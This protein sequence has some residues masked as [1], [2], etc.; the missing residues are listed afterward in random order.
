MYSIKKFAK[1]ERDVKGTVS[2][3]FRSPCGP[4]WMGL[5]LTKNIN[6]AV[7]THS[8][9]PLFEVLV[10]NYSKIKPIQ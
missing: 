7:F 6:Y 5:G 4:I 8:W 1:R 3:D 9:L 2:P 10:I